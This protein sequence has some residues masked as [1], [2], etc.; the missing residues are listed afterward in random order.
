MKKYCRL[1]GIPEHKS[2]HHVLKHSTCMNMLDGGAQINEVQK[3]AGHKSLNSTAQYLKGRTSE[4]VG[5]SR[6][7]R[8]EQVT[9][10]RPRSEPVRDPVKS[11]ARIHPVA[12]GRNTAK[13]PNAPPRQ[14]FCS[15]EGRAR[16]N[17][18]SQVFTL[19]STSVGLDRYRLD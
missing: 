18:H 5:R 17:C 15:Q 14:F 16:S 2:H 11:K 19:H 1:A 4:R 10:E 3:F 6:E 9:S 12:A 13:H 7:W 8:Y